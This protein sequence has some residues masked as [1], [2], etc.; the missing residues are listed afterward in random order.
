VIRGLSALAATV[1]AAVSVAAAPVTLRATELP[2]T[3]LP[4]AELPPAAVGAA[5]PEPTTPPRVELAAQPAWAALGTPTPLDLDVEGDPAGLDVRVLL[6]RSV[7][8][9]IGFD[10]TVSGRRLGTVVDATTVPVDGLPLAGGHRRLDL[11]VGTPTPPPPPPVPAEPGAPVGPG[12]PAEPPAPPP[13]E[14]A[15][16]LPVRSMGV[17]PLEIALRP[18]GSDDVLDRFVTSLV[19]IDGPADGAAIGE[20]LRVA[21]LWTL[22]ERP[23]FRPDGT[24]DPVA[25]R[26]LSDRGRI[27]TLA[28]TLAA[29]DLPVTIAPLPATVDGWSAVAADDPAT[30]GGLA[31]LRLAAETH[32][33]IAGPWTPIDVAA[34]ERAGLG[35]QVADLIARGPDTLSNVL[36]PRVD[37]RIAYR[38]RL[39]GP[40]LARLRE[41]GADRLVVAPDT[42]APMSRKLTPAQPFSL[43]SE[44]R[45]FLAV[46]TDPGLASLATR[47]APPA[48]RAQRLLAGLAVVALE[49]PGV[50]RGVVVPMPRDWEPEP[51]T[52]AA[53]RDGLG[54]SPLLQMVSTDEL[55]D[56][57]PAE[58]TDRGS[59]VQ[60]EVQ[61]ARARPAPVTAEAY[62]STE[63]RLG[64][65]ADMVGDDDPRVQSGLRS[66]WTSLSAV[67]VGDGGRATARAYLGAVDA[68]IR[69][70]LARIHAPTD[71][72]VTL[73][74]RRASVPVS[75]LNDTGRTLSVRV[76]LES[77]R[78]LFPEG[79]SRV[80]VLPPRNT[81]VRI[82][83]EVRSS[84]TFPVTF[85]I[86]S[87]DGGILIQ[88]DRI[89]FRST[90]VS[91]MGVFLTVG[92][93]GFLAV[94]WAHHAHNAR[95]ER[96]RRRRGAGPEA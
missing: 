61:A 59:V 13:P 49:L 44:G 69:S 76:A 62:H 87:A 52:I 27:D 32:E 33:V 56:T 29:D 43:V 93:G 11:A 84:G 81:T 95:R 89:T 3:E 65:F 91:G 15:V 67:W 4:A 47:R 77:D 24:P 2:P 74:S 53:L 38:D 36:G 6:H 7:G 34:L 57:V 73:T 90:V 16:T 48:L 10:E 9:R 54:T 20:P 94:W 83:V 46:E 82:P 86:R 51:A 25:L 28:R 55:F 12:G 5:A 30:R 68:E 1:V 19:A 85:T 70:F 17:Y 22:Q 39:D 37:T 35:A 66:M 72:A 58:E 96:R 79:R 63:R 41:S 75:I 8:S 92:A 31:A 45:T 26:S 50:R 21:W 18:R 23:V 78:L 64:A 60:R 80:V 14:P 40:T 71:R 88:R 42:L